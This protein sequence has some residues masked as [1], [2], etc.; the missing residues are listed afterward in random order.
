M[1]QNA[2]FEYPRQRSFISFPLDDARVAQLMKP[3]LLARIRFGALLLATY[4]LVLFTATHV[5]RSKLPLSLD[6]WDKALH[7][8]AYMVLAILAST[9]LARSRW[10]LAGRYLAVFAMVVTYGLLDEWLQSLVP[11]RQPDAFD[12]LA[13]VL[14][15]AV[16]IGAHALGSCIVR[17]ASTLVER[18]LFRSLAETSRRTE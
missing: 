4:W 1:I 5:P 14:G 12:F 18:N 15:G 9:V 16:G 7:F 10:S 17:R 11:G 8:G 2:S 3:P 13:D 6:F